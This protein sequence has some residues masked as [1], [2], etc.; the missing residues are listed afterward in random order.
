MKCNLR[1]YY[2]IYL[3]FFLIVPIIYI[4][5]NYFIQYTQYAKQNYFNTT[6]T[7]IWIVFKYL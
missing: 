7:Y 6:S 4:P 3:S 2:I 1:T 5:L